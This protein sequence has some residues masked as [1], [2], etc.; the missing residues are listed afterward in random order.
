MKFNIY[1]IALASASILALTGCEKEAAFQFS[2]EDGQLNSANLS[3][4]YINNGSTRAGGVDTGDFTVDFVNAKSGETVKSY[5]FSEIP[6]VV[7][8]PAGEYRAEA[9]YGEDKIADWDNPLYYGSTSFNIESGKI[10]DDV[11]PIECTL[12]NM[13][14]EVDVVDETGMDVVNSDVKV[15]VKAGERGELV[16]D[17]DHFKSEGFFRYDNSTTLIATL[18]GT[19]D[20]TYRDNI[21]Q[22]YDD[23]IAGKSYKIRFIINRP[24]NVNDG[25]IQLG[26]GIK[27]N[28]QIEIIPQDYTI[29]PNEPNDVIIDDMRPVEGG[30]NDDPNTGED[31]NEN[32]Q[33]SG[34]GPSIKI[35]PVCGDLA[36]D[37]PFEVQ[38]DSQCKFTVTS[39]ADSGFIKFEV[40]IVSEGLSSEELQ[41]VGLDS[42]LDLINPK[43][44]EE[45]LST[46]GFPVNLGGKKEAKFEITTFLGI[47]GALGPG[48]HSFEITVE[49]AN[50]IIKNSIILVY[51]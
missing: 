29:D 40:D 46:L 32:P 33:P 11:E 6:E 4:N 24:D 12:Q 16:Y 42:H 26:D 49:D 7:S 22:I 21:R 5:L 51:K 20:G 39:E 36:L 41:S 14:V 44:L 31:P 18:S 15:E 9:N 1:S 34:N 27:V 28:A 35:D 30:S 19:I 38:P 48:T 2:K 3:V 10:T 50:G 43:E 45:P 13:K 23:A 47:L 25:D 8:L 17:S 37:V